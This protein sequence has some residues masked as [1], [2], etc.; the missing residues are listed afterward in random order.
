M[1]KAGELIQSIDLKETTAK[2]LYH[3]YWLIVRLS[4]IKEANISL[5]YYYDILL[6]MMKSD[7]PSQS[8]SAKDAYDMVHS[9]IA[10]LS[11][12]QRNSMLDKIVSS[13]QGKADLWDMIEKK[14]KERKQKFDEMVKNTKNTIQKLMK[15][16]SM[17][18]KAFDLAKKLQ[19]L[20][21]EDEEVK[22]FV[23]ELNQ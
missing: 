22:K 9:Y 13:E 17:K 19:T 14:E 10:N 23:K 2:G 1:E 12:E 4:N 6:K 15:E 20:V 8:K 21:P 3:F 16:K 18:N 11:P 5:S 7:I